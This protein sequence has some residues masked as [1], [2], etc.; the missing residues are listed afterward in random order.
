MFCIENIHFCGTLPEQDLNTGSCFR[1]CYSQALSQG[2]WK[3]QK[4]ENISLWASENTFVNLVYSASTSQEL[5]FFLSVAC[6][7]SFSFFFFPFFLS[8]GLL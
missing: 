7:P 4:C 5:I 8:I 1:G 6:L 2:D 3:K